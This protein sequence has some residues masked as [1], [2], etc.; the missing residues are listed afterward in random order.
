M[1]AGY[2]S[3]VNEVNEEIKILANDMKEKVE[4]ILGETL[5]IYKPIMFTNKIIDGT[6]Y[7]IKIKVGDDNYM[8]LKIHVPLDIYNS[9]N[10]LLEY[11]LNMNISDPL[12]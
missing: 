2:Y 1:M 9:P 8:H 7:N 4:N 12:N 3:E 5:Q 6:N 10:E 11:E